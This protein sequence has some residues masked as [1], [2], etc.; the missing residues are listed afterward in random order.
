MDK[1]KIILPSILLFLIIAFAI[2]FYYRFKFLTNRQANK[3]INEEF[4]QKKVNG[5]LSNIVKYGKDKVVLEIQ[6]YDNQSL[7]Y[8]ILCVDDNFLNNVLEKDSVYK[9][10]GERELNFITRKKKHVRLK[11]VFCEY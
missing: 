10:P 9:Y 11:V 6:N 2:G 4:I 3:F 7:T 5:H 8:G 1:L